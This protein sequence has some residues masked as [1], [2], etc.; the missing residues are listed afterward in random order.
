MSSTTCN[1]CGESEIVH[2][3]GDLACRVYKPQTKKFQ[4]WHP[5][6][7]FTP[8]VRRPVGEAYEEARLAQLAKQASHPT[9]KEAVQAGGSYAGPPRCKCGNLQKEHGLCAVCLSNL[10]PNTLPFD[11][12][13]ALAGERL[14]TRCGHPV[15]DFA[16][17]KYPFAQGETVWGYKAF[18]ESKTQIYDKNGLLFYCDRDLNRT[19]GLDLFLAAKESPPIRCCEA[20]PH[21]EHV[22]DHTPPPP[23]TDARRAEEEFVIKSCSKCDVGIVDSDGN[24]DVC[25]PRIKSPASEID[26]QIEVMKASKEAGAVVECR[27]RNYAKGRWAETPKP[28]WDW[29]HYDYRIRPASPA[30]PRRVFCVWDHNGDPEQFQD[31]DISDLPPGFTQ[32]EFIE[33]TPEVRAKLGMGGGK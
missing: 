17:M 5:S 26:R 18:V 1:H 3:P 27:E 14:V 9:G 7:R 20:F 25:T 22:C 30:P 12:A 15:S 31:F 24:C 10:P 8:A 4:H 29:N 32:R 16:L 28:A 21:C 23:E 13:K 2:H 19:D 33:L 11:L 6:N